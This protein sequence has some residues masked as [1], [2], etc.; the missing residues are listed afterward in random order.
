MT[1]V[2][3]LGPMLV[4][5]LVPVLAAALWPFAARAQPIDMSRGGPI[6]VTS[7]DG[8]EW[9][10]NDQMVIATGDA[11]A[12]RGNVTVTADRLIARYR[13]K[14]SAPGA[15]AAVTQASAPSGTEADTGGNEVYRL[16]AEGNVRIFTETDLAVG[17]RAVYD[18]DQAV[19]LM[20]GNGMTVT[21][22][23]QVMTARDTM[24]YWS[25]KHMAV[26]RGLAT[27]TTS[28][29]RRVDGDILVGYTQPPPPA[30]TP[31]PPDA[32]P[33]APPKPGADPLTAS[34]KLER[35]E[36][37][38]NVVVRTATETIKADRGVYVSETGIARLAGNV[39]ITRGQNQLEGDEALV[40]MRTGISTMIREPG[41]RVQGLVVPNDPANKGE[42][43]GTAKPKGPTPS[44]PPQ[45]R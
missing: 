7:R 44:T 4:P 33:A 20:T 9:R 25:Q 18:I 5:V 13:K 34:G 16:E 8:M 39:H 42:P 3:R 37:F 45:A 17:D 24:E 14:A 22:P 21:T 43:T 19:L 11:R 32:K 12:V 31:P 15:P 6:D 41:R 1:R 30:G 40:N 38:G 27:V 26:G 23:Q 35:V 29:G 10:Q 28:D 2:L 36:G